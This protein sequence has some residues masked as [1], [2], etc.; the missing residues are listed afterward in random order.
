MEKLREN[1]DAVSPVVGV[2]LLVGLTVI[3]IST[4]AVS[5][6]AFSIPESAPQAKI[7]VVE[8]KGNMDVAL[9]KNFIALKHKGGD[10]LN[11]N[12]T[13]I[14][15]T[16]KGY[17]YN[18]GSYPSPAPSAQD[19]RVTYRDITG[20]NC[21][22]SCN[23]EIVK[24]TSWDAGETIKLYGSDGKDLY[25]PGWQ[26]NADSRWKLDDGYTVSVTIIDIPTNQVIA[27]SRITVKQAS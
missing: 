11:E 19:I 18:T 6:F 1:K 3:M 23:S 9:Y 27:T 7:V 10:S 8:T 17:A 22:I 20:E 24:G 25:L 16:G 12:D 26:N 14:I 5:V 21:I 13:K 4:I 2:I 15:I